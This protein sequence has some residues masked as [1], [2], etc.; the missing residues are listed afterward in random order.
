MALYFVNM[1]LWIIIGDSKLLLW[2]EAWTSFHCRKCHIDS[3]QDDFIEHNLEDHKDSKSTLPN[4]TNGHTD[5]LNQDK[6]KE[7]LSVSSKSLER[8]SVQT[9]PK[10]PLL[11]KSSNITN[12]S[13]HSSVS[14]NEDNVFRDQEEDS[15]RHS[16]TV[17]DATGHLDVPTNLNCLTKNTSQSASSSALH[18]IHLPHQRNAPRIAYSLSEEA[19]GVNRPRGRRSPQGSPR[20]RRQPTMETNS[21]SVV[22]GA[23]GYVQLNQYKLKNEIG[24]VSSL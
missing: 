21:F 6:D 10:H 14:D 15:R 22:D 19:L 11:R 7:N 8:V 18:S 24:K 20:L 2:V 4:G 3:D 1:Q 23:D 5:L 17:V 16:L 9:K 13:G 12:D